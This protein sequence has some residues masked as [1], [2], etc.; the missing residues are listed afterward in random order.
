MLTQNA[1]RANFNED[2]REQLPSATNELEQRRHL[3]FAAYRGR[4]VGAYANPASFS[5]MEELH[6]IAVDRIG[7]QVAP[8]ETIVRI[9]RH[10]HNSIWSFHSESKLIG[11]VALLYLN[12]Y[13]LYRLLN[14]RLDLAEP[15]AECLCRDGKTPKAIYCWA[16]VANGRGILGALDVMRWLQTPT[17][18]KV[19]IW[20]S[21]ATKDGQRALESFGFQPYPFSSTSLYRYKRFT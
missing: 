14:G 13:G 5:N 1:K 10:N 6:S 19:D 9:Q 2:L 21:P 15:Q 20:A 3:D 8:L 4:P 17:Y 7:S 12:T 18:R 11:G 16:L